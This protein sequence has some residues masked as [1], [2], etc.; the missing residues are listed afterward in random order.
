MKEN[1]TNQFDEN[2]RLNPWLDFVRARSYVDEFFF[3]KYPTHSAR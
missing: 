3:R 1:I 2:K